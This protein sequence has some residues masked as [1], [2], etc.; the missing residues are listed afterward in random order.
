MKQGIHP[1]SYK[2]IKV[3]CS[4]GHVFTVNSAVGKDI[5]VDIC[6]KCHPFY[7]KKQKIVDT[8]R[9][10]DRFQRKYRQTGAKEATDARG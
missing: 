8:A 7:T 5:H 9:R 10:V 4:C 3:S 6:N 2:P 1:E